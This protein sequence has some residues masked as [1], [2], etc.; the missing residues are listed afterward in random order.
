MTERNLPL[1]GVS[2]CNDAKNRVET[3]VGP[4][5]EIFARTSG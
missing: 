4:R 5:H 1:F 2:C 3:D